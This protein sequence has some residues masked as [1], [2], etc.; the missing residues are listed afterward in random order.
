MTSTPNPL[1]DI[2]LLKVRSWSKSVGD[3][4]SFD[5]RWH[6]HVQAGDGVI[7]IDLLGFRKNEGDQVRSAHLIVQPKEAAK[8]V[9]ALQEALRYEELSERC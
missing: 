1:K 4:R 8:I 2:K 9:A 6:V 7:R 3:E 5:D